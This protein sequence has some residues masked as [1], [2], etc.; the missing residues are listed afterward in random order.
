VIMASSPFCT[1]ASAQFIPPPPLLPR[2]ETNR[3]APA[4]QFVMPVLPLVRDP[5]WA[6]P[7]WNVPHPD[8]EDNVLTIKRLLNE[9]GR[10]RHRVHDPALIDFFVSMMKEII[11]KLEDAQKDKIKFDDHT[12]TR[13]LHSLYVTI[14][15]CTVRVR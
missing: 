7:P 12:S 3:L 6:D 4:R 2:V 10:G 1:A 11:S 9:R 15:Q 13:Q 8:S 5:N 14:N